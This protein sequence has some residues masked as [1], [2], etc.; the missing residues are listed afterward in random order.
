MKPMFSSWFLNE[1][2]S[3]FCEEEIFM[4]NKMKKAKRIFFMQQF[5]FRTKIRRIGCLNLKKKAEVISA[6]F[7]F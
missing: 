2:E 6:P 7:E 3:A 1:S 5:Y 4:K